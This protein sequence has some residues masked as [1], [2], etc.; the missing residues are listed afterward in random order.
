MNNNKKLIINSLIFLSY[1]IYQYIAL[2]IIFIIGIKLNTNMDKITYLLIINIIYLLFV[3]FIYRKELIGD[4][5]EFK[6]KNIFRYVPIYLFGILLMGLTNT[7][8]Y[9][10]TNTTISGNEALVRNYIKLFP[11]YM[12]FSTVIYAPVMEEIIFRKTFKNVI[13][14]STLFIFISGIVFG[15]V[16]ISFSNNI[17]NDLLLTI[18]YIIMG[19][20]FAY[21]YHKS[22]NIFTT[23]TLHSLHNLILLIIQFIGG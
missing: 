15:L 6:I 11:I 14:N 9:K 19:I 7:I 12:C 5:K 22:N 13:K 18:P 4:L 16:H 8:I 10:I 23:I 17:I 21:I 2:I 1:F 3:V 20:D